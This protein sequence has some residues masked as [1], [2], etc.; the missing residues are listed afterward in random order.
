MAGIEKFEDIEAWKEAR[1]L[2]QEIYRVTK[3]KAFARDIGLREQLQ[4][5]SVSVM[6]NIA[7]GFD[8]G[9]DREFVKF[10][11]YSMRSTSELQSHLYVALDQEYLSR[12]SFSRLY[13]RSIKVKNLIGGFIRYLRSGEGP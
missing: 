6:A 7:E 4:R 11:G 9:S 3:A 10:L 13:M 2:T 5:A 12:E 8:C 1:R